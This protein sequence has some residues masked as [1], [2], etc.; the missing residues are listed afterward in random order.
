MKS[1]IE[2]GRSEELLG[3][4][5]LL[6]HVEDAEQDELT[7]AHAQAALGELDTIMR[8]FIFPSERKFEKKITV[9]SSS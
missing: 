4:Y 3:I 7:K 9:L 1:Y 2:Q 8:D 5:R 6:K